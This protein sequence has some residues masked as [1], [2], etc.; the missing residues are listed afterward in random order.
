ML[1]TAAVLTLGLAGYA[2]ELYRFFSVVKGY[3]SIAAGFAFLPMLAAVLLASRRAE[4]LALEL[5]ARRLIAGGLIL[6]GVAMLVTA[7]VQPDV[8]YWLL[9]VPLGVFGGGYLIAQTA[10]TIAFMDEMPDAIVGTSAGIAQATSVTGAALGGALVGITLVQVGQTELDRRLSGRGLSQ[11]Q[12]ALAHAAL[13]RVLHAGGDLNVANPQS[14]TV[15]RALLG[16][17]A[18]SYT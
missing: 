7:L 13:D 18:Q 10:W 1:L 8:P 3:G 12:I 5:G 9:V 17:Y 2:V 4:T 15:Q 16:A 14:D 6:M 11:E